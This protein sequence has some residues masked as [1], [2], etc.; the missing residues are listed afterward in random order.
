MR[1]ALPLGGTDWGQSGIG[2]YVRAVLPRV[3][4]LVVEQGGSVVALGTRSELRAYEDVL[5]EAERRQLPAVLDR[6]AASA[7]WH[8]LMTGLLARAAG[9]DVLLMLAANRR[10]PLHAPVPTVGVVHDVAQ[11]QIARKYDPLRMAYL[12]HVLV[13]ALA[14]ADRL[15]AVSG[16]TRAD[17][18]Q[19]LGEGSVAL[20][21]VPNGVDH[22]RFRP[23]AAEDDRVR[24]AREHLGFESQYL[25]Y[26]ARLEHPGKN[27]LR[28]LQA[29][30]R[31]SVRSSHRLVLAGG[32]WGARGMIEEEVTRLGLRDRVR[33]LGYVPDEILPGLVAGA[34]AVVM[35][36]LRE[37]FGLPALEALAAG[38]PV[39][40]AEA[41][42]LPE[43]VGPLAA[44]CDPLDE[45]AI[46]R[47]LERAAQD[48]ELRSRAQ[49]QGPDWAASR[50]WDKT[51]RGLV[52]ACQN[53]VAHR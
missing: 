30:A 18:L 47:G 49:E 36:G 26:P 12:R 53:T 38:R 42:A 8:L 46:A 22:E 43:V 28:L 24:L 48:G 40:A 19:W 32:D 17:V 27:H 21:V 29:F 20:D 14:S 44:L 13:G 11:L 41:G 7:A 4:R 37:G 1:I 16:A 45:D 52:E 10:M 50:G 23:A 5:G 34:D 15:V 35:V 3:A 2:T 25:L 31:S 33:L 6:P 51:A 39:C 9:A